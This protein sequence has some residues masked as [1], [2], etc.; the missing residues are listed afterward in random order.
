MLQ[1]PELEYGP[2]NQAA[3]GVEFSRFFKDQNASNLKISSALRMNSS[4]P[5][6]MP[7]VSLPSE[8][9]L[10]VMDAGIRDNYGIMNSTQF[11]YTFKDW[12]AANTSGVVILQIR[13]THKQQKVENNSIKSI[14]EKVMAPLRNLSGNFLIMQDYTFDRSLEY[15]QSW[16]KG[17]LDFVIIQMPEMEDKISLSWHLTEKEKK[18]LKSAPLNQQNYVAISRLQELVP[19]AH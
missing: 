7:S 14:M 8:P 6:I 10:E 4:F 19:P 17:P 2:L 15:A 3:N 18:F 9:A 13:D 16:F 11:L 12:I 1:S 5:Y